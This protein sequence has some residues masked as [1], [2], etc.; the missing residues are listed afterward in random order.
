MENHTGKVESSK[1]LCAY[2]FDVVIATLQGKKLDSIPFPKSIPKFK[3][4]LFVTWHIN[5]DELRG[6]IGII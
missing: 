3:A 5:G 2:C 1:E 4:P 6:C